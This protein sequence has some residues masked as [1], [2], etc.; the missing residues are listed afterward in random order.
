MY[1]TLTIIALL[2]GFNANAIEPQDSI[3]AKGNVTDLIFHENHLFMGTDA[4]VVQFY[5]IKNHKFKEEVRIPNITNFFDETIQPKIY[6]IDYDTTTS[7][8]LIVCQGLNGFAN[9]YIYKED[10]SLTKII[11]VSSRMMIK[12]ASFY[13][14]HD[15]IFGLLSN[16]IIRFNRL[17]SA[18]EYRSQIST[19]TFSDFCF[20]S[21][22][23]RI[24]SSDE[25]GRVNVVNSEDGHLIYIHE[26]E[27]LDNV[28][29]IDYKGNTIATAGQDRRLGVYL[30][31]PFHSYYIESSFLIYSV[32]LS[33]NG[34]KLAYSANEDNTIDIIDVNTKNILAN[35][36]AHQALISKI[37]FLDE[38]CLYTAADEPIVYYW[39][40]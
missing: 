31:H 7:E 9:V 18:I 24:I 12:Q 20:S 21:S 15:I 38:H 5:D 26:G 3:K 33:P 30:L 4:G 2:I 22:K 27:N 13:Q 8:L 28:Y 36:N 10:K 29:Q 16:E 32:G 14:D 39:E 1:K 34:S 35:L 6:D 40:F 37:L 23:E 19:Y 25:S 17:D 11:D